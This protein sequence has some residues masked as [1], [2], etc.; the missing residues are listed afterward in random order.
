M[1][2]RDFGLM[3]GLALPL[4][5]GAQ[6]FRFSN[7]DKSGDAAKAE[8]RARIDAQLSTPCREQI[9]NRK[10]VVLIGEEVNGVVQAKQAQFGPHVEAVN[11]RLLNLGL[12]TY[13]PEEIRKQIAQAEVDAVMK[14]NPDAALSA[15]KR[16]GAQYTLKGT[17]STRAMRNPMLPVNQVAVSMQFALTGADGGRVAEAEAQSQSFSGADVQGM[18]LTLINEQAEEVVA[19]LYSAYCQQPDVRRK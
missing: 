11:R 18:A 8:R 5:A 1:R 6:G 4:A 3:V 15:A 14:N 10:I 12:R 19:R 7:E 17:I 9:R 13:A 2:L 16:L